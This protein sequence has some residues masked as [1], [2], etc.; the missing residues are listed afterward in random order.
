MDIKLPTY[1]FRKT[2]SIGKSKLLW[3]AVEGDHDADWCRVSLQFVT[4]GAHMSTAV[5]A[6]SPDSGLLFVYLVFTS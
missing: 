5:M 6:R 3:C 2:S 4:S 1:D